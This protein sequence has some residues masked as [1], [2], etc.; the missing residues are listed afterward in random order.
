MERGARVRGGWRQPAPERRPPERRPPERQTAG[1]QSSG[2]P[3]AVRLL[4]VSLRLPAASLLACCVIVTVLLG[5]AFAGQRHAG[6]LD[7]AIDTPVKSALNGFP[8]LL[9]VLDITGTLIPVTLLTLALVLA[10][11]VTRR[12]SGAILAAV[13][14]P[15]ASA[16][17]EGALKPLVD[18]TMGGALSFPSGHATS[19]FALAGTCAVLLLDPPGHRIT[20]A[21]R[22]MLASLALLA[23]TAVAI[24]MVARGSHYF[25][26]AVGG[27]A[28]GTG[29]VLACAL[30]LDRLWPDPP[31]P[32][33]P[34]PDRP[35]RR[36]P[37]ARP[38][39]GG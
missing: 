5:I 39:T 22:L 4:P 10:C 11:V 16:L 36:E 19:M 30:C 9:K 32:A 24:A 20:G 26:D 14:T 12:W 6:R 33:P 1:H 21:V 37:A 2:H 17:T 15:A 7:T 34:G 18:R 3:R 25:T 29:T 27:T 13:A 23:A 28:V 31:G 38:G 8:W 35:A